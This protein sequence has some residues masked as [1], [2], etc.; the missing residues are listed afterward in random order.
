MPTVRR[1][2]ML[3]IA[4]LLGFGIGCASREVAH[5]WGYHGPAGPEHWGGLA[6][7]FAVART[8]VEQSPID[9]VSAR[10]VPTALPMLRFAYAGAAT[11]EVAHNGHTVQADLIAGASA[12]TVGNQTYDVV[13]FHFHA[14]SE[15][16]VDGK[17]FPAELHVVHKTASGALAVVGVLLVEGAS[18]TALAKL[19]TKG[20]LPVAGGPARKVDKFDLASVLPRSR[21]TYRYAGSLTTPPCTEGVAWI[22]LAEPVPV[23][24]DLLAALTQRFSGESFPHGNRRP[25]QALGARV[26][27]TEGE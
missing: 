27:H 6:P 20:E 12:I 23:G 26:V 13:Q 5:A 21:A 2:P 14:P 19:C 15:H 22:V 8:G 25:I 10:V 11:L 17:H 18:H 1:F 7:A 3:A 24:A 16:T 9:I 4:A